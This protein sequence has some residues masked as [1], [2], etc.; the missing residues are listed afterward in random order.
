V[1]KALPIIALGLGAFTNAQI[2]QAEIAFENL[3]S[4]LPEHIYA[5]GWEHFVGGGLAVFDCNN[6]EHPDIFAAGGE[7]PARLMRNLGAFNFEAV[8]IPRLLGVT[9]AYPIDLDA[10]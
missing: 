4:H 9:G 3:S 1:I 5:G 10:D 6:D 7:N 8:D 2:A